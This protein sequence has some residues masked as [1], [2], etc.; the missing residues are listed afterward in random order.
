MSRKRETS[1]AHCEAQGGRS[2]TGGPTRAG[3]DGA[4][5]V[6]RAPRLS[7]DVS[8]MD[9][10]VTKRAISIGCAVG[11]FVAAAGVYGAGWALSRPV[12]AHIGPAPKSLGAE[13][14]A[15]S[16]ESGSTIHGWLSRAPAQR[17]SV[18]LLPGV[19]ANRLSMLRRAEFLRRSSYSTLLID[20]QA[21]GES[22]GEAIAFG[23]RERFDVLAGVRYLRAQMPGQPVGVVGISL[24]GAATLLAAPPLEVDAAVLEAVYPSIDRAI[25]NR[26]RMRLGPFAS[27]VAPLLLVQFRPRLHVAASD[28]RPVDHVS[29]LGCPILIVGGT[30]DQHTTLADTQ[31]LFGAA[32]EPKE[33]WL[34]PDAAHVDFLEFAGD[35]YRDRVLAFFATAFRRPT[36]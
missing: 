24:G 29:R 5:L 30:I 28:L 35:A 36:G 10:R 21:T 25:V 13:A 26:L 34:I 27:A 14:V 12:P 2:R 15:F 17:G 11:V 22:V 7:A 18:L 4:D 19:R 1:S 23:W 20:F 3:A 31:L 32:R 33:L 6:A 8:R 16:S 9:Q